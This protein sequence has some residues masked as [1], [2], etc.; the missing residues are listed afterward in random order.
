MDEQ[1]KMTILN[2]AIFLVFLTIAFFFVWSQFRLLRTV[3]PENRSMHPG[4]VWLQFIPALGQIWQ[5]VVVIQLSRSVAK[6]RVSLR[7]DSLL[8]LSDA[9]VS[10]IGSR[11]SLGIGIAY[12]VLWMSII[13]INGFQL[14]PEPLVALGGLVTLSGTTCFIIY[15]VRIGILRRELRRQTR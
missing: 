5:L 15:W 1:T 6:E 3:R 2:W 4:L 13:I 11:P 14:L 12:W 7:E 10:Q 8:G 9:A